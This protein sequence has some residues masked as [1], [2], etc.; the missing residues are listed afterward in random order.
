MKATIFVAFSNCAFFVVFLRSNAQKTLDNHR[1]MWY[2]IIVIFDRFLRLTDISGFTHGETEIYIAD[3]L[4]SL[5]SY[6]I[7]VPFFNF[8]VFLDLNII[9]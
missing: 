8:G 6:G 1:L 7:S 5:V 3:R 9:I 2:D 4:G